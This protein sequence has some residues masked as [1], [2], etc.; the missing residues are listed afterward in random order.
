MLSEFKGFVLDLFQ[1]EAM[2]LLYQQNSVIVSAPTG[3]GKT[4]VI[5]YAIDQLLINKS[6]DEYYKDR[7]II[8]TSPIKALSN[9]KYR[10]FCLSYGKENIGIMTGDIVI[11]REAPVLIM[12]TEILR[13]ILYNFCKGC[14]KIEYACLEAFI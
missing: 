14:Y 6:N 12:T 4:L 9:Q 2:E 8:Y 5:D 13:N 10:D 11:N 7:K 1:A 3:S